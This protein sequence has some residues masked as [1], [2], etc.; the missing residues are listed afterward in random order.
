MMQKAIKFTK[1]L[2][3]LHIK[4]DEGGP[5]S[6]ISVLV[7]GLILHTASGLGSAMLYW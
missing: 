6:A 7:S 5:S 4:D 3:T 2:P 1:E